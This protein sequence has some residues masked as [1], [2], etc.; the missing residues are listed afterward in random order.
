MK[1]KSSL[2]KKL[3][4]TS[5]D[6]VP[7][8]YRTLCD[9]LLPRPIRDAASCAEATALLDALAVFPALN[10]EQ[11]DYLDALSHFIKE[12]EGDAEMPK[13]SGLDLLRSLVE[14]NGL[15]AA[16]LSRILGGSR[17][18]GAMILRGERN[19]TAGH[20]RALGLHFK[21]SPGAFL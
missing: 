7:K 13:V 17:T 8:T 10:E 19:I 3:K 4:F 2:T 14:E 20:A 12:Y 5:L 16:G 6:A 21:L 11:L 15:T 1:T 18:L 9:L